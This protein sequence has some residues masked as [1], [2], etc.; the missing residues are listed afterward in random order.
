MMSLLKM[1]DF[2]DLGSLV[3]GSLL[4]SNDMY[5]QCHQCVLKK[6]IV[7]TFLNDA[8]LCKLMSCYKLKVYEMTSYCCDVYGMS[9]FFYTSYGREFEHDLVWSK[10]IL[11]QMN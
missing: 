8:F 4:R 7:A 2:Y 1:C 11:L 9:C 10:E 5:S 6:R 3:V